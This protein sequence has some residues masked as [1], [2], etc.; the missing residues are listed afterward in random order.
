MNLSGVILLFRYGVPCRVRT[1]GDV[2]RVVQQRDPK[3]VEAEDRY[4]V[5]GNLGLALIALGTVVQIIAFV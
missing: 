1:G 2:P 3:V 5:L 4:E